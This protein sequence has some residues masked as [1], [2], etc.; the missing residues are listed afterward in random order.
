MKFENCFIIFII[1][2]L[3][4]KVYNSKIKNMRSKVLFLTFFIIACST[5]Q[6]AEGQYCLFAT[7]T[8]ASDGC[9]AQVSATKGGKATSLLS[10][11]C[12]DKASAD[13]ATVTSPILVSPATA[14]TGF[15]AATKYFTLHACPVAS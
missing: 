15:T 4:S 9:C 13:G 2:A 11:I 5:K 10:G 1:F 14:P 7:D 8:C 12:V 6:I 3:I